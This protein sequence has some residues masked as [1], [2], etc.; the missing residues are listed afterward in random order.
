VYRSLV[1]LFLAG[2]LI[3]CGGN[4]SSPSPPMASIPTSGG[5]G[6]S[7]AAPA[8]VQVAAGQTATGVNISVPPPAGTP[9]NAQDLGV[10][11]LTGGASAFNT[12]DIIH[13][14]A[15][16]R[17]VLFGPGLTSD[18][19]V[20]VFGPNDLQISNVQGITATDT[21]PGISFTA[22]MAPNAAL[23]ARTVVLQSSNGNITTFTGGLEVV[24]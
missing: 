2:G 8:I 19:R 13:Q 15:T 12:G 11:P 6:G 23:G 10:A 20:S 17:V 18:M 3:G 24:P 22:T 9:A 5:S 4:A 14:G 21:T 1:T 7:P 16:M